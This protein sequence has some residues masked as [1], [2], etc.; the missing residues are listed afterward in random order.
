MTWPLPR[1]ELIP[2]PAST[3]CTVCRSQDTV[4]LD[5]H[6]GR[7]CAQ[8]PP[9]FDPARAVRLAITGQVATALAYCR[10]NFPDDHT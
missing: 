6:H 5:S 3:G 7:R 10:R 1:P 2:N 8:H 9:R 4:T